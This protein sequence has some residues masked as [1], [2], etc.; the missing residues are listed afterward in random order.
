M[1]ASTHPFLHVLQTRFNMPTPG[2]EAS[3]RNRP[4]WLNERFELFEAYCL[5]SVGAQTVKAGRD[6][7]W[8]IYFD[9]DTPAEF[10]ERIERLREEVP[11]LPFYT[12]I[13]PSSGWPQSLRQT[14]G[15]LPPHVLTSRLDNDD[16]L[17][18]DYMERTATAAREALAGGLVPDGT[19]CPRVGIVIT[20]GFIRSPARAYSISHPCNVFASWLECSADDARLKTALG[21]SHMAAE[22]EGPLVQVPGPGGWL[23]IIHGGNVSNK[24]RGR[25]ISA[26]D[27]R[28]RFLPGALAGLQPVGNATLLAENLV[29]GPLRSL[30]DSLSATLQRLRRVG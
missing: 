7:I 29:V 26:S 3:F 13:F 4:G 16:A 18:F 8:I 17:A 28:S 27:L 21:I 30:R 23:Q 14:L 2:R 11:F 5:P 19:T 10:R 25:R 1:A 20:N 15:D 9:K 12:G 24:V 6:F 22:A